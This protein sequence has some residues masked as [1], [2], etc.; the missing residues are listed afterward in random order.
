MMLLAVAS[1]LSREPGRT[2]IG[3]LQ[4]AGLCGACM[5]AIFISQQVAGTPPA[6]SQ[7]VDRWPA[8]MAWVP[9]LIFGPMAV[10]LL[11]R[12]KT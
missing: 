4:C 1:V 7:W 5:A 11:D 2:R 3:I 9:I 12:V 8:I 6:G 10:W